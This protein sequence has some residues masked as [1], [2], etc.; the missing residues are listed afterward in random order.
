M[1]LGLQHASS[2]QFYHH[3][4]STLD[5]AWA[6]SSQWLLIC[7]S[8]GRFLPHAQVLSAVT[9]GGLKVQRESE[10]ANDGGHSQFFVH[11]TSSAA[12]NNAVSLLKV[13][14]L[15]LPSRLQICPCSVLCQLVAHVTTKAFELQS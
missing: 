6:H 14:A 11:Y 1:Y 9:L 10:P 2:L 4:P 12:A 8:K 3:H 15:L 7:S 13:Y 5:Q